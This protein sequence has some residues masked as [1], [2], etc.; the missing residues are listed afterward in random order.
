[1]ERSKKL[2]I[3][4][5]MLVSAIVVL[6][7][8]GQ[9]SGKLAFDPGYF[10]I[11]QPEA[12]QK[13]E[14]TSPKNHIVVEKNGTI[15]RVNGQYD[16]DMSIHQLMLGMLSRLEVKRP[17]STLSNEEVIA[18]LREN[19]TLVNLTF[20]DGTVRSFRAGGQASQSQSYFYK[21][22]DDRAFIIEIPGY[23]S[24]VSAIFN[25]TP[26][27]WRN[28]VIFNTNWQSLKS[29][30]VDYTDGN[31]S[32]LKISPEGYFPMVS[33]IPADKLDSGK[34]INY[35]DR[36]AYFE[37][38]EHIDKQAFPKYDSLANGQ[39]MAIVTVEDFDMANNR[40]IKI[41]PAIPGERVQLLV[42]GNGNWSVIEQ[43]RIAPILAKATDFISSANRTPQ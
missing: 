12:M 6:L 8:T 10:T 11:A 4:L 5:L 39:P 30:Q 31:T 43:K 1:M 22:G 20:A 23:T 26:L 28:R 29:L 40:Q 16:A 25:L 19:G 2:L 34:L 41:Y 17:V 18:N 32:A 7:L 21:D 36:F 35:L 15:W 24:Y 37:T 27:Q 9:N 13:L 42:D 33:G 3:T 38:N 14:F